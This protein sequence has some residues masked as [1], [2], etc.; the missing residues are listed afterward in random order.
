M[1]GI[2]VGKII[3]LNNCLEDKEK[4]NEYLGRNYDYYTEYS[5]KIDFFNKAIVRKAQKCK[6]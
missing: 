6:R 1:F 4:Y 2:I 3:K 5:F